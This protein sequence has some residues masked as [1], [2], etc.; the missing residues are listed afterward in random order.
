MEAIVL[1]IC[2]LGIVFWFIGRM[3]Y[4]DR[5]EKR[6]ETESQLNAT[7][8]LQTQA[9]EKAVESDEKPES[10]PSDDTNHADEE[11][12]PSTSEIVEHALK[13]IG[14]QPEVDKDG[15]VS[16]SYQGENFIIEFGGVY[17]RV[18]DPEWASM[19]V[20]HPDMQK[21]REAVNVA[22]FY[23]GP[24]VVMSRPD[25]EGNV[26]L[27]SR[28][29]IMLHTSFPYNEIYIKSVLDSFFDAKAAV[30]NNLQALSADQAEAQKKRR[31]V[32]FTS[33]PE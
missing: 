15:S 16:V 3:A 23:F 26:S 19:N 31:P 9:T 27:H 8:Q 12:T 20:E 21:L 13:A 10:Q 2:G 24:T 29:D 4:K 22:N 18:W 6:A 14:C 17:A 30:R 11:H 25:D 7:S 5:N 33:T 1:I 28:I 32:G